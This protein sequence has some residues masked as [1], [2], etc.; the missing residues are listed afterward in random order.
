MA[1]KKI[2]LLLELFLN[3]CILGNTWLIAMTFISAFFLPGMQILVR[4]NTYNEAWFELPLVIITVIFATYKIFK[5]NVEA[6]K[7]MSEL[8]ITKTK[9]LLKPEQFQCPECHNIFGVRPCKKPSI[10]KCP[11]CK[12]EG[13]I[14]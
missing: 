12:F 9:P 14:E 6:F 8:R 5:Y 2:Y 4:I 1:R 11:Y 7:T 13:I 10:T 3:C